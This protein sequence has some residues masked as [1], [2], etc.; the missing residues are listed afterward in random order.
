MLYSS[1]LRPSLFCLPPE[2]VHH[3]SL[4]ALRV[5]AFSAML[6]P[7]TRLED[8][9]LRKTVWGLEFPNPVGLAAGFDKNAVA[10]PAWENLGFGFAEIGTVT[11]VEQAGNSRPRLFRLPES[12][13]IINRLGFPNEG[14]DAVAQR[15]Q[16]LREKGR[17]PKFPVGINIG[18]N[19][20]T[21]PEDAAR[22]YL[23]C[24]QK[25]REWGDY[26]VVNVSS[27]N[28]PG[29]RALQSGAALDG[30]FA[31]LV[32]ENAKGKARPLLVKIAPDITE[33][34][35]REVLVCVARH[36]LDG[37]VATNT[38]IDKSQV[39]LQEEGGL[40]GA[41]LRERSTEVIRLIARETGGKLPI[42]GVGGIFRGEE[43]RQKL[44]AGATLVQL[45][46]GFIYEGPTTVRRIGLELLRSR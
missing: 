14:A 40:S 9:R 22:D 1:V 4:A 45:Y 18:K 5:P 23:V 41:P 29:L 3:L 35:I 38:T 21:T 46:T 2:L 17:W 26:F 8:I 20:V 34:Q 42:I 28:T 10:L 13:G 24:F 16:R 30:I 31:P 15:L 27:P 6:R 19:K 37:I 33:D 36:G 12:R 7:W 43:A 25:L 32:A 44:E 39:A 11:P